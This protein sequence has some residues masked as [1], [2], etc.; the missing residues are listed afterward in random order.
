MIVERT[1]RLCDGRTMPALGL[2][3]WEADGNDAAQAVSWALDA[4]YRLIDT[5]MIYGNEKQVGDAIKKSSVPRE[6]IFL[7]TKVWNAD[8]GY[9]STLKAIDASLKRLDMDYVDLYLV[10]W[11]FTDLHTMSGN[12]RAETWK[13]MEEIL[14]S[15]KAKSIGVSNY[16][17]NHLEEMKSYAQTMP[18]VNQIEFHPFWFRKQLMEYCHENE[19]AVEDYC[20]L[21][22]GKMIGDERLTE[23]AEKYGKS[24]AQI[25]IRW[26]LQHGNII[27]PK[28]VHQERIKENIDVFDYA[29]SD[30]DMMLLDGLND[31]DS[32]LFGK[33][34]D[35][36]ILMH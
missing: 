30:E 11:P 17:I 22:R 16:A 14:A 25:L 7:T 4:G 13:A 3:V 26:G 34:D 20:P 31:N 21:S 2:G 10:H 23:I 28:S 29:L 32:I 8:Q 9:V 5:A 6:D 27:I 1:I 18:A 19:I 33:V 35:S 36:F 24:N 12:K 15:E